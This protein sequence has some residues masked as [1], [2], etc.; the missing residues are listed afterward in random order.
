[1]V[2]W[3]GVNIAVWFKLNHHDKTG[4]IQIFSKA[5]TIVHST[6]SVTGR[7]VCLLCERLLKNI[8]KVYKVII[9]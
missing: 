9:L 5:E 2:K 1:M 4:I 6:F 8:V 7:F 3:S